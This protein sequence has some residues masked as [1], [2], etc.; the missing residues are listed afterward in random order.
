[1]SPVLHNATSLAIK[2]CQCC[3]NCCSVICSHAK[4]AYRTGK[5]KSMCNNI[6]TSSKTEV[7]KEQK[8]YSVSG[9]LAKKQEK[10]QEVSNE[11]VK[12]QGNYWRNME[13]IEGAVEK[14]SWGMAGIR[15]CIGCTNFKPAHVTNS[16]TANAAARIT[17]TS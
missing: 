3:Q 2:N 7:Q 12:K 8:Y 6:Q 16:A 5:S 9:E 15:S 11:T 13:K 17:R 10:Y 1:M 14:K 4:C